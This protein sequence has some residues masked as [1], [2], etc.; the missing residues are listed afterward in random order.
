MKT[1]GIT[2]DSRYSTESNQAKGHRRKKKPY[3]QCCCLTWQVWR[4]VSAEKIFFEVPYRR[5]TLANPLWHTREGHEKTCKAIPITC[6][7]L[8]YQCR[9]SH[10]FPFINVLRTTWGRVRDTHAVCDAMMRI[11]KK[12]KKDSTVM[13]CIE[14]SQSGSPCINFWISLVLSWNNFSTASSFNIH[15]TKITAGWYL[16]A[17]IPE[18]LLSASTIK[19]RQNWLNCRDENINWHPYICWL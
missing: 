5:R 13:Y 7:K 16:D 2:N 12:K 9:P 4:N 15:R 10:T 1:W 14:A 8:F 6:L 3:S 18:R 11:D 19:S 17:W